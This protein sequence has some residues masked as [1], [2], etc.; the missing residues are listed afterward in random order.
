MRIHHLSCGTLCPVGGRLI[1][2]RKCRPL[3]GALA[4]HCLLIETGAGRRLRELVRRHGADV[5]VIC[6]HDPVQFEHWARR[7]PEEPAVAA[8]SGS[9]G[10]SPQA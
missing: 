5:R 7:S 3:R 2:E 1:S 4:C 9:A 10:L 8:P 6:A